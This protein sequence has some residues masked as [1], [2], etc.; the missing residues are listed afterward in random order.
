M[1][2]A[3]LPTLAAIAAIGMVLPSLGA[4][5]APPPSGLVLGP[6]GFADTL[7]I[8]KKDPSHDEFTAAR[9]ESAQSYTVDHHT[10]IYEKDREI[11]FSK[12]AVGDRVA[13]SYPAA[14]VP[15]D[16]IPEAKVVQV[17][18]RPPQNGDR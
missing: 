8:T 13:I 11:P 2:D 17:V 1:Q 12:L 9:G 18:T 6:A 4:W 3:K 5:A 7:T 15:H 14:H 16:G 10:L